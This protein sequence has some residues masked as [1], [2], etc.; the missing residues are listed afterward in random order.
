MIKI[1]A[2]NIN[3]DI[4][5]SLFI[6]LSSFVSAER[7]EKINKFMRKEDADRSLAAE[8]LVRH[9]LIENIKIKNQDISFYYN[10]YGKPYF[11]HT[12]PIYFNLSHSGNWVVCAIS[13]Q[14]VGIDVEKISK[15]DLDIAKS[16]FAKEE[17]LDLMGKD[18]SKRNEYFYAL[19][20]LKE[21][22]IKARGKGLSLDLRSFSIIVNNDDIITFE[23]SNDCGKYSFKQY[24]IDKDYKLSVCTLND[25]F[26][27]KIIFKNLD[28]LIIY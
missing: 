5:P 26:P 11:A 24:N 10:T 8:V 14:E 6:K 15:I 7:R 28:D 19:W 9:V 23:T 20:T 27:D 2:L 12:P 16:F 3:K 18:A 17:Y 25:V 21:S 1:Y 4:S 22:Y 13:S